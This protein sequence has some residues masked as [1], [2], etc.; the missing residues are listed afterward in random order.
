MW[1]EMPWCRSG[2]VD[3]CRRAA[4]GYYRF[5]W[6]WHHALRVRY[7]VPPPPRDY[8]HDPLEWLVGQGSS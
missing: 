4:R 2:S 8:L 7:Y 6:E 5:I 3:D 1:E